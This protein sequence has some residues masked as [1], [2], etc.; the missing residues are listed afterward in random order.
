MQTIYQ[1]GRKEFNTFFSSPAAFIFIG[2]F[3][4]VNL[5]IFFWV[6]T[7]FANNICEIRPLFKW[8]P[9]LL[10]F[11]SAAIT[12]RLWAEERR[13][14]TLE[15]LLT[16]P[17]SSF[18]LVLGKFFGC[19]GLIFVALL[20]TLPLPLSVSYIGQLDWGPVFGGYLAALFLSAAYISIG[21]WV[22]VKS[23]NQIISLLVTVLVCSIL[24]IIGSETLS[25]FFATKEIETLKLLGTG[26]RFE[27][28]TRGVIDFRDL[29][30]YL[31]I[32][33]LFLSFNTLGLEKIRWSGNP[34][35][36]QHRLWKLTTLI[37]AVNFLL[38]NFW[39]APLGNLRQDFTEGK[40]YSVSEVTRNYLSQ[41]KEPLLIRGYFSAQTHPLLAPLVPQVKD[42]LEEYSVSAGSRLNLEFVDPLEH[43]DL[44][45]EAGQKYG[46]RPVPFQTTSKYQSS[47]T[48]SYFDILIQY[49][50]QF[51]V[52]SF[53]DLIEVKVKSGDD[54][55]VELRNPEYDITRAVRKVLF[56][57]QGKGD[58]FSSIGKPIQL[59]GYL[60]KDSDLPET[61]LKLKDNLDGIIDDLKAKGGDQ[62]VYK[63]I[64]PQADNGRV[65]VQLE[66]EFGFRPMAAS[67]FDQRTFWFYF[68]LQS[69]DQV[70]EVPLPQEFDREGLQ[71]A[72]ESSLK[73]FGK[74][75]TKSI[76]LHT[77]P[78]TQPMPQYGIPPKGKQFNIIK[79]MLRQEH[80]VTESDLKKGRVPEEADIL[81]LLSP[82][83]LSEKQLFSVDQFLMRGGTVVL[84]T[85]HYDIQMAR[86]LSLVELNSGL[87]KWLNF[88]G[89]N[90]K[91]EI[92]MDE[93]NSPF[94]VPARRQVGGFT[95]QETR[96]LDYPFFPDIR[97]NR[98]NLDTGMLTGIPQLTVTWASPIEIDQVKNKN[99]KTIN[100]FESSENSWTTTDL[101]LQPDFSQFPRLGFPTGKDRQ[102]YVLGVSVEGQFFSFFKGKTSPLLSE[103]KAEPQPKPPGQQEQQEKKEQVISRT[104]EKSPESSRIICLSSNTFLADAIISL[105]SGVQ[106]SGYL[107]P[108]QM[109][110][111]IV[112]YSLEDKGLLQIRGRNHF[113]RPLRPLSKEDVLIFEYL[114]YGLALFSLLIL[115]IV[116][117]TLRRRAHNRN[118]RILRLSEGRI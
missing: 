80:I 87:N 62:F 33:G 74:G 22:S 19:L 43:P 18:H 61:L 3:L 71:N 20:L 39:L 85:S 92:V 53:R 12:M 28:I 88:H 38:G 106:Q 58:L 65:A 107:E 17:I 46:I 99:R 25:S 15:L 11:L 94:P 108:A 5:F 14:G 117:A 102:P 49:G 91:K 113:S 100:L 79:D 2:A 29:Y 9:V 10:I 66:Q 60:S 1:I 78:I 96:M 59:T 68:L 90:L 98:M 34:V 36:R 93:Q 26:S 42:L 118:Q 50:D 82:E 24:Y 30:Y 104:I 64:D 103:D 54:L 57:Y 37:V 110:A 23:E 84:A 69:G 101:G 8:M 45:R 21:L 112:D 13:A 97:P 16:S 31:S 44:E 95:I 81:L 111:N 70:V 56:S 77:Q 55:E 27:S 109:M 73:R 75:F 115:W 83:N 41:L 63:E 4:A 105:R 76:A 116:N 72:I 89:I 35:N 47:V 7:F 40:M 6:E 114:N 51:E 86:E 52:L 32:V 67:I 48:N